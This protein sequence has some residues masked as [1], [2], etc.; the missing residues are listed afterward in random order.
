MQ[1]ASQLATR[2]SDLIQTLLQGGQ[3]GLG[4]GKKDF[5]LMS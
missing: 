4:F 5:A 2:T 3:R 1:L